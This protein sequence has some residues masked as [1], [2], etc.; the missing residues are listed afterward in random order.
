[1]I[2]YL[3]IALSLIIFGLQV[4]INYIVKLEQWDPIT[5]TLIKTYSLLRGDLDAFIA[6]DGRYFWISRLVNQNLR[7]YE[8]STD[9]ARNM[10]NFP[11]GHNPAGFCFEKAE[12]KPIANGRFLW[13]IIPNGTVR[14]LEYSENGF[15]QVESFALPAGTYNGLTHDGRFLWTQ[16][17]G[18]NVYVKVDPVTQTSETHGGSNTNM[19]DLYHDGRFLW[20]FTGAFGVSNNVRQRDAV[21]GTG[22]SNFQVVA[23]GAN[24]RPLGID[25]DGR[26]LWLT[27]IDT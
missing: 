19:E 23:A 15:N 27:R 18:S 20:T 26:F 21:T 6:F 9:A 11:I 7:Q 17:T 8:L 22:I 12:D 14:K 25:G 16:E 3:L 1:L 4:E 2:E 24:R 10:G 13:T 5:G